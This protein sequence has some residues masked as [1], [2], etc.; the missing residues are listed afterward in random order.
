MLYKL[1]LAFSK[2]GSF[3]IFE[4]FSTG[5]NLLSNLFFFPFAFLQTV[6]II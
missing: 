3:L 4:F 1:V 2:S 5:K 6:S